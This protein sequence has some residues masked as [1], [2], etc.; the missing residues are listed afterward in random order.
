MEFGSIQLLAALIFDSPIDIGVVV[1]IALI[2]FGGKKIPELMRGVG[3][4]I[5]EFRSGMR[6]DFNT[7]TQTTQAPPPSAPASTPVPE[8]KK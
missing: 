5:R 6:D 3:Q 4:G 2:L 8:Q 1:L 7:P